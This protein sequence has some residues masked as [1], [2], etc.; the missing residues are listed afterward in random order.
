MCKGLCASE[1]CV[2]YSSSVSMGFYMLNIV[3]TVFWFEPSSFGLLD[4]YY[5]RNENRKN[6]HWAHHQC[7][8]IILFVFTVWYC[9]SFSG[10]Q[11]QLIRFWNWKN[12][13]SFTCSVLLVLLSEVESREFVQEEMLGSRFNLN[14]VLVKVAI[15]ARKEIKT[16]IF[17]SEFIIPDSISSNIDKR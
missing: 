3:F 1:V 2:L 12:K 11:I 6:L 16:W 15:S 14:I 8:Q 9:K 5:W 13:F 10:F 17:I 7:L 4:K